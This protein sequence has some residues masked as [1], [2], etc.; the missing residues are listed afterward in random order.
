MNANTTRAPWIAAMALACTSRIDDGN[1]DWSPHASGGTSG[2]PG[3][4]A[5]IIASG[6]AALSGTPGTAGTAQAV[7]GTGGSGGVAGIVGSPSAAGSGISLGG[8][9]NAAGTA[10]TSAPGRGGGGGVAGLGGA[11]SVA[12]AAA[13]GRGG[14]AAGAGGSGVT[15]S[16]VLARNVLVT[17]V[18]A[19]QG[20]AVALSKSGAVLP[21]DLRNAQLI[22]GRPTLVRAHVDVGASWT[23][24]P[25][26]GVLKLGYSDGMQQRTVAQ[27]VTTDSTADELKSTFNFLL[28]PADVRPG[29]SISVE[30]QETQ[31]QASPEP[32]PAPRFPTE[33]VVDLGIQQGTMTLRVVIVPALTAGG[34]P[35]STEQRRKNLHDQLF[36]IY[37]V[38][39]VAIDWREPIPLAEASSSSAFDLMRGL[40]QADAAPAGVIYHMIL[41]NEDAGLD[42]AG[43]ATGSATRACRAFSL[44]AVRNERNSDLAYID[45]NVDTVS[46]E[47]G[48]NLGLRHTDCGGPDSPDPAFPYTEG[49]I[50]AQGYSVTQGAIRSTDEY[51]DLMSYCRPRWVS[52]WLW[53]RFAIA[54]RQNSSSAS[55]LTQPGGYSLSGFVEHNGAARWALIPGD[56]TEPG[57]GPTTT[58]VARL[59]GPGGTATLPISVIPSSHGGLVE[60]VVKLPRGTPSGEVEVVVDGATHRVDLSTVKKY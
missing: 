17:L 60:V 41:R 53:N 25:I 6:S 29:M 35:Q 45:G 15:P 12:G 1:K 40:C 52:D 39:N 31:P 20:T 37:P 27:T 10:G 28:G 50:G 11:G 7:G 19:N 23:P 8:A 32:N 46:H 55:L 30:L 4:S 49:F 58:R 36:D 56:L 42:I 18:D 38:Q 54:V 21:V 14:A 57:P 3:G 2:I 47:V 34:F 13:A 44:T 59:R 9:L 43:T 5:G 24:R 26:I 16:G 33:G 51:K 22:E 48:H